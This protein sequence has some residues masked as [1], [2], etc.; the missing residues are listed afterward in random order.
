MQT[1]EIIAQL[2]AEIKSL[3]TTL[4]MGK[5]NIETT[6]AAKVNAAIANLKKIVAELKAGKKP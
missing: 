4:A 5:A 1:S 6:A 2:E 3:E